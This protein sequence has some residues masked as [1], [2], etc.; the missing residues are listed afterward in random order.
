M[1]VSAGLFQNSRS[2]HVRRGAA[3]CLGAMMVVGCAGG[4]PFAEAPVDPQSPAGA[5][6]LEAAQ[7]DRSY[8]RFSDIPPAP[9]DMRPA[10]AWA[11]AVKD[12][13]AA[14]SSLYAETA[15]ETWTLSDTEAFAAQALSQ[16]EPPPIAGAPAN[17]EGFARDARERATPPPSSR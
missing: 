13:E 2:V 12:V 9:T 10:R 3:V 17:T 8:P 16:V 1:N 14:R 5:A 6:I 7:A 11:V 15:P 4:S